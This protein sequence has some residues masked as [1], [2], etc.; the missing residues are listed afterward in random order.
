MNIL[1]SF[2]VVPISLLQDSTNIA[3]VTKRMHEFSS[4]RTDHKQVVFRLLSE[5]YC[6]RC[7][8]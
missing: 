5:T 4:A 6:S 3:L 8:N 2:I 1:L 7:L